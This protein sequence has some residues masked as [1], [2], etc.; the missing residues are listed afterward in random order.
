MDRTA[1]RPRGSRT[2]KLIQRAIRKAIADT[3]RTPGMLLTVAFDYGSRSSSSTPCDGFEPTGARSRPTRS[4]ARLYLPEL[5]PVDVLVRTSG[6]GRVSNFLLWQSSAPRCT[7]PRRTGRSSTAS[8]ST[9]RWRWCSVERHATTS[10]RRHHGAGQHRGSPRSAPHGRARR[11]RHR[12]PP[13]P[14]RASR[15]RHGQDARLP[16]AGDRI[17][18]PDRRRHGDQDAAGPARGQ[19]PA[20]PP[21]RD[22]HRRSRGPCSRVAATTCACSESTRSPSKAPAFRVSWSSTSSLGHAADIAKI[23]EWVGETHDGDIA[24]LDFAIGRSGRAVTV[25][26]DECPGADR[27]PLGDICFA[28]HGQGA[29]R[30]RRRRGRQHLPLRTRRRRRRSDPAG[31]RCRRARRGPRP[32]G[33]HERH[34]RCADRPRPVRHA[35]RRGAPDPRRPGDRRRRSWRSPTPSERARAAHREARLRCRTPTRSTPFSSTPAADSTG[36]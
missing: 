2:P 12:R 9:P 34:R 16:R 28:E 4:P 11:S 15:H 19:G 10:G 20:V 7:S 35:R 25:G 33:H 31:P 27:C 21:A 30:R 1:V 14:G 18:R 26:S 36:R 23:L 6:E 17:G 8:S 24:G 3:A 5:P 32:R 29:R 22:G 13:P